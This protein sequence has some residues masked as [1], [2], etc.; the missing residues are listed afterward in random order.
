[1]LDSR[2]PWVEW[3]YEEWGNPTNETYYNYMKSYDPYGTVKVTQYPNV[4]LQS[5]RVPQNSCQDCT[6]TTLRLER[7]NSDVL[8]TH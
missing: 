7:S 6:N 2:L 5:G 3:E 8:G 1:M 4:L